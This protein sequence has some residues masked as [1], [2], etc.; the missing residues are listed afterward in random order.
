MITSEP[1]TR[2]LSPGKWI[3][4]ALALFSF[5]MSALVSRTVFE[6]MPHLEDE[7]AYLFEARMMTGGNWVIPSP[8]LR[9][10]FWQPFVVDYNGNRFSK[11]TPGW[12]MQL[13]LGELM[14]QDWVINAFY[15]MLTVALVY[16]LA[17]EIFNEDTG[18]IAAALT[19]FSPA[20]LLLNGSLMGHTSALFYATLFLYAYWRL[21]GATGKRRHAS[22]LQSPMVWGI[23]AGIA[24]GMLAINR[25][26]TAVGIGLPLVVRSGIRLIRALSG[27]LARNPSPNPRLPPESQPM[28]SESPLQNVFRT[29]RPL[30]VLGVITIVIALIIPIYNRAASGNPSLNLY[31]LVWPYDTV[32]F[33]ECCGRSGHT[34]EKGMRHLR[35]DM[36]LTAA[37]LFGWA[38][39]RVTVNVVDH[40]VNDSDYFPLIGLSFVLFPLAMF[41]AF[42]WKALGVFAWAAALVAWAIWPFVLWGGYLTRDPGFSWLWLIIA[43]GWVNLPTLLWR[44]QTRSWTWVLIAVMLTLVGTQI[45]YWVGSQR[46]STRYFYEGLASA[47]I[48][49]A[50][51]LAW[52]ARRSSRWFVYG[53]LAIALAWSLYGY[54]TPRV[55]ALYRYNQIN[56]DLIN[57]VNARRTGDQP[58]LVIV[59]GS[60]VRWRAYG[61]LMVSTGPYLNTDIVAAQNYMGATSDSVKQQLIAMFP[62]RQ[63]IEMEASQN[64][65]VFVDDPP[66]G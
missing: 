36:S 66:P 57:E 18:V 63:V 24:L 12:S 42:R 16:R 56:H 11:Y 9:R 34:L 1:K 2:P 59:N 45:A 51:P 43:V 52:A 49:S 40:L 17:R 54:S 50:L 48:L 20:A 35:Y 30:I 13:A 21:E 32:G 41:T 47:A 26:V 37:D 19:A 5:A 55:G 29:L 3:V 38:A 27:A 62:G 25:P 28:R 60:D 4:L 65:A 8:E 7:V 58:V 39:G 31:T 64:E 46:Y 6:R 14:G 23:V 10:A 61:S 44:D 33:G 53:G 22:P 15:A